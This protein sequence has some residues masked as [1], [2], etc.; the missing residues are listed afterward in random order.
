MSRLLLGL[1]TAAA[2]AAL[3]PRAL[4]ATTIPFIGCIEQG[5]TPNDGSWTAPSGKPLVTN[6]PPAI[7]GKLAVYASNW[8]AVL[9][10]RGWACR[11]AVIEQRGV[12]M[13]VSPEPAEGDD[14]GILAGPAIILWNDQSAGTVA[15]YTARYFPGAIAAIK[16]DDDYCGPGC[17]SLLVPKPG[18]AVAAPRFPSDIIQHET[19]FLLTYTTPADRRGLGNQIGAPAQGQPSLEDVGLL[20]ISNLPKGEGGIVNLTIR[21]PPDMKVL[22]AAILQQFRHCMPNNNTLACE[23]GGSVTAQGRPIDDGD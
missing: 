20:G 5:P 15:A 16:A 10:P 13:I 11:S 23:S 19:P 8:S 7:A 17:A 18:G 12:A 21:L 3:A 1:F 4:A 6:L 14:S 22:R 2:I 9:A